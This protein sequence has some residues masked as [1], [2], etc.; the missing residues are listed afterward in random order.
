MVGEFAWRK[1][2]KVIFMMLAE[3]AGV[4]ENRNVNLWGKKL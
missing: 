4:V 2:A 3:M 1:G